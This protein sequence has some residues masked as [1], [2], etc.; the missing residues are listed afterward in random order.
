MSK[1]DS[2]PDEDAFSITLT[3]GPS[4]PRWMPVI[5][6]RAVRVVWLLAAV[7][8]IL[9]VHLIIWRRSSGKAVKAND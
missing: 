2:T 3:T 7:L 5:P 6:I 1:S 4:K 9:V 8:G